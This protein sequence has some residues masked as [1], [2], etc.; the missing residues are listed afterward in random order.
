MQMQKTGYR[1]GDECRPSGRTILFDFDGVIMRGDAFAEFVRARLRR[2]R[3]R[4]VPGLLLALPLLPTLP[5]TRKW[6]IRA[7]V[8]AVLC[9][10]SGKA[11]RQLACDFG[12]ELACQPRRFHREALTRLR[13]HLADGDRVMIVTGCEETLVCSI[14]DTLGL[15]GLPI[16]ASG[17]RS[18]W[19]GMRVQLHN[20]G[21][22][23]LQSLK[24]AGIEPP[25]AVAYSDSVHDLPMLRGA[26]EAVLVNATPK[27][28][29]HVEQAL[30]RSVSRVHW[31]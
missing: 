27:R 7:F 16:L 24:E 10:L 19:L 25:W 29:K 26:H 14:F 1:A 20:I 12:Y 4:L 28:C 6:V 2:A 22:H 21:S 23:K 31:Q 11:Y 15:K 9:G 18:G 3:W 13:G 17:L 30:G 5:F 8:F